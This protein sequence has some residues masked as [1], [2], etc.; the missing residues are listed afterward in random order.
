MPFWAT[1]D[2]SEVTNMRYKELITHTKN[3]APK[4]FLALIKEINMVNMVTFLMVLKNLT[5]VHHVFRQR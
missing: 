4:Y 2:F 5:V 3:V 1:D